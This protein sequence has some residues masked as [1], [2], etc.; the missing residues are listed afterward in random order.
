MAGGGG[1]G[2]VGGTAAAAAG[3]D[4]DDGTGMGGSI[5]RDLAEDLEVNKPRVGSVGDKDMDRLCTC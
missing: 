3:D 2:G 5:G 1:G 4:D